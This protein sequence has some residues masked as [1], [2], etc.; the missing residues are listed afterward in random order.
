MN[1]TVLVISDVHLG[2]AA[3]FQM[4][5]PA[6]RDLLAGFLQW[7][8]RRGKD[9]EAIELIVNGDLVD[10]LAEEPFQTLT[11]ENAE[12]TRKLRAIQDNSTNVWEGFRAVTAAG[13]PLTVLLGNHDLELTLPGPNALLRESLG[14]G[15]VALLLDGQ[16]L[17]LGDV[18][19]EHGNRCDSWNLVDYDALR[20]IGSDIS[21][22][23]TPKAYNAPPGSKLVVEVMNKVKKELRFVD[24]L[25][26]ENDAVLPLLAA[27]ASISAAQLTML[28][29][30]YAKSS[31]EGFD[32]EQRPTNRA[33]IAGQ[34][35][36][37]AAPPTPGAQLAREMLKAAPAGR[38]KVA[39]SDAFDFIKIWKASGSKERRDELLGHVYD[40]LRH[41]MGGQ[42]DAFRIDFEQNEYKKGANGS[43]ARDFK[44][45]VYGHT[46]LAKRVPIDRG[47]T[48]FNTGTWA[49]LMRLPPAVVQGNRLAAL[50]E[51]AD[52]VDDLEQNRLDKWRRPRP[53]F[54]SIVMDGQ[55]LVSADVLA[56]DKSGNC[57][58]LS[59]ALF[60]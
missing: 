48:Y 42:N 52:F 21:R 33:K 51:L 18:L 3:D 17:D 16:A 36:I 2:G 38:A 39:A 9:G 47:A 12:A 60:S 28:T 34:G 25:K 40:A 11:I 24:L 35:A 15:R 53:T 31:L 57:P 22:R 13:V 20:A 50:A 4:C 29:Q 1:R 30:Y 14:P 45:I 10:F 44:A 26:P 32:A 43:A 6:G 27:L 59:D 56:Y 8:A 19:V 49:D 46:H 58:K 23:V 5:S 37:A 7:V 55:K 54:A 41:R